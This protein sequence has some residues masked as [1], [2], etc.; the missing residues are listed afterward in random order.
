MRNNIDVRLKE[1]LKNLAAN[2]SEQK[3]YLEK[4]GTA[5]SADELAL[6]FD[7]IY[8]PLKSWI[9]GGSVKLPPNLILKLEEVDNLL[10]KMSGPQNAKLWDVKS[11][12]SNEWNHIRR[13]AGEAL[14]LIS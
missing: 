1:A 2:S 6:E 13:I 5:P 14:L 11:L 10:E 8:L 3:A 12:S 7:D 9:E 4:L